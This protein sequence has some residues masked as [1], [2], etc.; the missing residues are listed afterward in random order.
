MTKIDGDAWEEPFHRANQ[1][2]LSGEFAEAT[3]V[4]L[5]A[6]NEEAN[7]GNNEDAAFYSNVL[8]SFLVS[9]E[10]HEEALEAYL[11]AERLEPTNPHLKLTTGR[12][13]HFMNRSQAGR[14]KA[15]EVL[16]LQPSE[17]PV[18]HEAHILFALTSLALGDTASATSSFEAMVSGPLLQ[19]LT[20]EA[21]DLSLVVALCRQGLVADKCRSYLAT[22]HGKALC[23]K[24]ENVATAIQD[25]LRS[26]DRRSE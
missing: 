24:N 20:A 2:L 19:E 17:N 22:V 13:L 10:R 1:L 14:N 23:E 12:H 8:G 6:M 16:E 21:C 7:K 5:T 9:R 4:L 25:L 15:R 18:H 26:L 11:E 3:T